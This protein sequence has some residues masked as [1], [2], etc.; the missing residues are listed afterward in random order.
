MF[1]ELLSLSRKFGKHPRDESGGLMIRAGQPGF[2]AIGEEF[3]GYMEEFCG[4]T[5]SS[6]VLDVGCG[7]GRMA[8]PLLHVLTPP[9]EYQ[10]FD[11]HQPAIIGCQNDIEAKHPHFQFRHL[12]LKNP[13]YNPKGKLDPEKIVFPYEAE[14]FD[15][16]ILCSVF[17][18]M[19]PVTVQRYLAEIRRVLKPGGRCLATVFLLNAHA[20]GAIDARRSKVAFEHA[21]GLCRTSDPELPETAVAQRESD[22]LSWVDAAG[23]ALAEPIQYGSWSARET[24]LSF[25]D[26][27]V[28]G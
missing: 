6:R 15:I 5:A 22:F 28:L 21:W 27:V 19:N 17:T 26:V 2:E 9:G 25:Q 4:L 8:L 24:F 7:Y 1:K 3:R 23:M 16:V 13:R 10:G 14:E 20:F 11:V 12:P 18:H